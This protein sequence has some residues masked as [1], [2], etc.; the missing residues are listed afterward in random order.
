MGE[1]MFQGVIVASTLEV[2]TSRNVIGIGKSNN[3]KPGLYELVF[4][5][6][7]GAHPSVVVRPHRNRCAQSNK[8]EIGM[9]YK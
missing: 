3:G 9:L 5:C 8:Q 7:H 2:E 6:Y 4:F 1:S